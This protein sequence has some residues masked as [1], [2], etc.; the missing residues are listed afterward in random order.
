VRWLPQGGSIG[1]M[2]G[3]F[4]F[5][6]IHKTFD[7]KVIGLQVKVTA[8]GCMDKK[9]MLVV[10]T[11]MIARILLH[12]ERVRSKYH[13]GKIVRDVY[14]VVQREV[15]GVYRRHFNA[16]DIHNKLACGSGIVGHAWKSKSPL[17]KIFL[18]TLAIVETNAY[19]AYR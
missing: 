14:D 15:H 18:Y 12:V 3:A 10:A 9:A 16:I 13:A 1:G 6:G 4:Q 19:M 2:R 7:M 5:H 11:C 17:M 8:A